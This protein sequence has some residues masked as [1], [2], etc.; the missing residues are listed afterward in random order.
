VLVHGFTQTGR[1]FAPLLDGLADYDVVTPDL[2]GHGPSPEAPTDLGG[3][4][5]RLG[6]IGG[7]AAYLG[8]SMGGRVALHLALARPDLVERLVLVGV[9]AG[10]EEDAERAARR[11]ADEETAAGLERD[12]VEAFLARWLAQPLFATL[13]PQAAGLDARRENTAAGLAAALRRLGTGVQEPLW[14]RL[15]GLRPPTLVMAGENDDKYCE[16]ALRVGAWIGSGA[17]LAMVPQTGH[18]CHLEA[19]DT[20]LAL[21]LPWLAEGG[22]GGSST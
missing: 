10:I 20:F 1:S 14:N 6:E 4:A 13:S 3:A 9:T 18:A 2:P 22:P 16:L 15:L 8:Y 12:G 5:E 19:P 17:S 21:L 11:A 7:R